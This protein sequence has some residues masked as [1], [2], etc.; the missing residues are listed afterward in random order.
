MTIKRNPFPQNNHVFAKTFYYDRKI[1]KNGL[2]SEQLRL[3]GL[4]QHPPKD[5]SYR[6]NRREKKDRRQHS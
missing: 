3:V 6:K 2:Q 1:K 4:V 5:H